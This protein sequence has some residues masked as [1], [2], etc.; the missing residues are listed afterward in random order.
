M[1]FKRV[2][3]QS[4]A[5]I[6]QPL[7]AGDGWVANVNPVNNT[8][9]A[10]V[11]LTVDNI[12]GGLIQQGVTLTAARIWTLPTAAAILAA[13]PTMDIGDAF[14]FV[15]G[16]VQSAAFNITIAVGVGITAVGANNS[17][18]ITPPNT[19]TFTLVKTSSTTMNLY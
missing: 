13:Y 17:L 5:G 9:D 10:A 12:T 11:A 3:V 16:N 7:R 6:P 2:L 1:S 8:T 15:V 14:T 19:K 18:V 4:D